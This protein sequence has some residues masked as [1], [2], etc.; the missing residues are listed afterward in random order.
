MSDNKKEKYIKG[1][2]TWIKFYDDDKPKVIISKLGRTIL[3]EHNFII[4]E[5]G[6][7]EDF[8]EYNEVRGYWELRNIKS[9]KS[10]ITELLNRHNVWTD[11]VARD[12]FHFVSDSIKRVKWIDTFG[13]KHGNYFNFKN[14]VWDWD[15]FKLQEHAPKYYFT[16][17][18]DYDL[19]ISDKYPDAQAVINSWKNRDN[20]LETE[21]WLAL[22]VGENMQSM[23]EF[24]GYIFYP[25]YEPI[26]LFVILLSPGGDGKTTLMNHLTTLVGYEN[27]SFVSLIDLADKRPNNFSHSELY[28]KYLNEYDDIS[29]VYIPDTTVLQKLTGGSS[30]TAPVKNRPGVTLFNY[31]KLLFASNDLP[32]F[33]NTTNAFLRRINVIKFFKINNFEQT[34]DMTKVK[35]ERGEFVYKCM[36]LARDAMKRKEIKQTESIIAQRNNWI[37]D[38]DPIKQFI[39]EDCTLAATEEVD[40]QD[41]YGAYKVWCIKNNFKPVSKTKFKKELENK[42]IFRS[43]ENKRIDG[44]KR[45]RR[46]FYKGISLS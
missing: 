7:K 6:N 45:K 43:T 9:I 2:P 39:N 26:Q 4:V 19:V 23:M 41:L 8:Y 5:N 29:N 11:R 42:G 10:V 18:V 12:A 46:Y 36:V 31:A 44:K 38:N 21:K 16:S 20:W 27:T 13:K 17:C 25:S 14:G 1:T 37:E 40:E 35:K 32:S 22:S 30:I 3:N 33:S 28:N 24:I 34:V 15:A